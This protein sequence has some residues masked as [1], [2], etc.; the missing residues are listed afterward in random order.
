MD[1]RPDGE[2]ETRREVVETEP[3]EC[4]PEGQV[5]RRRARDPG[6]RATPAAAEDHRALSPTMRRF[7]LDAGRTERLGQLAELAELE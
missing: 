5:D 2:S 1:V 7:E 6:R 4:G 3:E